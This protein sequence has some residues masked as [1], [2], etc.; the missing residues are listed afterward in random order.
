[1]IPNSSNLRSHFINATPFMA[2]SPA[3][4][5][6]RCCATETQEMTSFLY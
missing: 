4:L 6:Q 5:V 2:N 1:M 3:Y